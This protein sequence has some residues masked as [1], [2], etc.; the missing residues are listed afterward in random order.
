[1]N[2]GA[3]L[4]NAS[5]SYEDVANGRDIVFHDPFT[6]TPLHPD[7]VPVS[8]VAQPHLLSGLNHLARLGR[9]HNHRITLAG[10]QHSSDS[11]FKMA[12]L[13]D[14]VGEHDAI[15]LEG[16]GHTDYHRRI[17]REIGEG[18]D[19]I[20]DDF[21]D[22]RYKSMQLAA[23]SGH[24]KLVSYADIPGDGT[25][26][27]MALIEWGDLARTITTQAHYEHGETKKNLFRAALINI[28]GNTILREWQMLGSL[29]NSLNSAEQ[30][31]RRIDN[32]LFLIGTEH[33]RTLPR[34][35]GLLGVMNTPHELAM[36]KQGTT[37]TIDYM[38]FDFTTAVRDYRARLKEF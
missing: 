36:H 11:E 26:Y 38:A 8:I 22:D 1:M 3:E 7:K 4:H 37:T 18:R 31:G 6:G 28:A 34:K 23:I 33:I 20:P 35:L 2:L 12:E 21:A 29:G 9:D 13:H 14:I 19:N 30:Q 32:S 24:R 25:D 16:V 17:V 10:A 15:F 5:Y 27:E